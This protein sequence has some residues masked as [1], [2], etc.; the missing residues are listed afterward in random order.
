MFPIQKKNA[1]HKAHRV[2]SQSGSEQSPQG[3]AVGGSRFRSVDKCHSVGKLMSHAAQELTESRPVSGPARHKTGR[4]RQKGGQ[5]CSEKY[6]NTPPT[7]YSPLHPNLG[8]THAASTPPTRPPIGIQIRVSFTAVDRRRNGASS[9]LR[10]L[11]LG[12]S[13][14]CRSSRNEAQDREP[15]EAADESSGKSR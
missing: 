14:T 5:H 10:A 8:K 2:A 7:T 4:F 13:P 3:S 1:I 15:E 9:A 12:N 11:T 6:G